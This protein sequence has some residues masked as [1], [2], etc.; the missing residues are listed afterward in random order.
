MSNRLL[1]LFQAPVFP[2][3][4]EKTRRA[5]AL[6]ALQ[7]NMGIAILVLGG[8]GLLFFFAEKRFTSIVLLVSLLV[9]AIGM[10]LNRRGL[11]K[12]SGFVMLV[13]LWLSTV[14]LT[15][16]SSG[17]QSLHIIFFISGTV[18][19]GIVLGARGAYSY[20]GISL[21]TGLGLVLFGS[22][23]FEFLQ[24]FSYPPAAVWIILFINLVFTVV[25]LQ[26][27]LQSLSDSALRARASEE[28]YRLIASIMSDY[29][30]SHQYGPDGGITNQWISG[31]FETITG[32]APQEY[33]DQGGWTSIVHPEEREADEQDMAQLRANQNVI[34]ERRI[35]RKDGKIRWVRSY[36]HP[37]WDE[38]KNRLAGIYGAVQDITEN[39]RV[40]AELHQRA[41]E[42]SL[43]YRLGVALSGGENLYQALRAFVQELKQVMA[44]DA[45]HIGLYDPETDIFSYS[46]FLNIDKDLQPPPR[47]LRENPGL[48][49]EVISSRKTLYLRDVADRQIQQRHNIVWIVDAP[50]RSYLGIPLM[51]QDRVMGIMSV[52]SIQPYAYTPDQVRLLETIAAQVAITIEKLSLLEQVQQELAERKKAEAEL[53]QREAILKIVADAANTFLKVSEW[54]AD[55]W[56]M[57]VNHLLEQ[58]VTA[59]RASHAYIFENHYAEDGTLLMSMRYE[60]IAPGAVSDLH[61]PRY[62]NITMAD[63]QLENWYPRILNGLPYIGD[64]EH[65][66]QYDLESLRS[67]GILALLDVP[68][69][70]DGKWWGT[71]GFD[72]M[73]SPRL[74]STAEVDALVVAANMLSAAVK[75]VQMDSTLQDELEQRKALIEELE[76]RNAESETLRESAAIV[77]ASL[78]RAET[79]YLILEQIARVVPYMS[80]SVQIIVGNMLEIV[81]S[82]G[83]DVNQDIGTR[84]PINENEPS[85]PVILGQAPYILYENIQTS[86]P[87]FNEIPHNN[88]RAWMAVPLKVKGRVIGLITMDGDYAGQFSERDAELAV[89]YAN[90][91]AIALENSRL[92]SELQKELALKQTLI[93]ELENKNAEL[94]RF[95][96]TVSHDLRSPLVT[97]R[98]FLGYLERDAVSG[99]MDNF[100]KDLGRISRATVRMDDLLKDVLELSRIGRLVNKPQDVPFGDLV[101]DALE[102]VHGRLEERRITLQAQPNLPLVHGDKPRLIEVLQNLMDNAA[103]YMGDQREPVIEIGMQGY[104]A[105]NRPVFFVRDNG[106]G[107]APEY[108]ER[109]FRLFDKLDATSEGTGVGL[110]LVKR[111]IE[112]HGGRIWVESEAGKGSTFLFTL[113][114]GKNPV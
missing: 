50:I 110:A 91:A 108:H 104:D 12:A 96:Y 107:I 80:A 15:F 73:T 8:A 5:R 72:D 1:A 103:K 102:I 90:Q 79:L 63:D 43:L 82:R 78:E 13:F 84:F 40:D 17:I 34:S 74:W 101:S 69:F 32:Y 83:L 65:A 95:T 2:E 41:D 30:F 66:S 61:N 20:A 49:W 86:V 35:I 25:P 33:F 18:V 112:F 109:I 27:A 21:L 106:M 37:K 55:T 114:S 56:H 76:K 85:H 99:N 26:V 58:L 51:L 19:A 62:A 52:Q 81:S 11:I 24:L 39:K 31:A 77:A 89:T 57:E 29:V 105:S 38:E 22:A 93:D 92:F 97:I 9:A 10:F 28:R 23:G 98:G 4:E 88:I 100:R 59:I 71:I 64:V 46:L 47:K 94:E 36:A 14:A 7:L 111:I 54:D 113:P 48:T 67:R 45:F 16:L 87:S 42:V 53:Q 3:D 68:I 6:N 70:I 75:R 60:G 44:V